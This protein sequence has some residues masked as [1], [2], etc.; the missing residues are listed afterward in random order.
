MA[1]GPREQTALSIAIESAFFPRP[2]GGFPPITVTMV[3]PAIYLC[4]LLIDA[5]TFA[6]AQSGEER[7]SSPRRWD[8]CR[9][10]PQFVLRGEDR[11]DAAVGVLF[12]HIVREELSIYFKYL[13]QVSVLTPLDGDL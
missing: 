4:R 1:G 7:P 8:L 3:L 5:A 6:I 9:G 13:C 11:A 12:A 10:I 2:E